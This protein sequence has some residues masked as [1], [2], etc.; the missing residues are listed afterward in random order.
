MA[1]ATARQVAVKYRPYVTLLVAAALVLVV[2]PALNDADGGEAR[3]GAGAVA[4]GVAGA[5][6][7]AGSAADGAVGGGSTPA[8]A[9]VS[10]PGATG[11]VAGGGGQ[12]AAAGQ[13][14]AED[15]GAVPAA[16]TGAGVG[17]E[18]ALAAPDCDPGTGRIR[19]PFMIAPPCV[20][21]W[22]EGA[23]NGGA[24]AQGVT[25]TEIRV[26][27][28]IDS[29]AGDEEETMS[30]SRDMIQLFN[31]MYRFWGRELTIE[32]VRASGTDEAA[33]RAD[34][35]RIAELEPFAL[36]T[37]SGGGSI[38][39]AEVA[40]RGIL[41][42]P[43]A[44]TQLTVRDSLAQAPY[45]WA[46]FPSDLHTMSSVA[47][48]IGKGLG[49]EPARWAGDPLLQTQPR[50]YG[51]VY[52]SIYDANYFAE[53]LARYNLDVAV[54]LPYDYLG[55]LGDPA[56]SQ[57]QAP[58][59]IARL[60]SA[61]VTTVVA[62]ADVFMTQALTLQATTNQFSP[63]W[64]NTGFAAQDF[65]LL[66]RTYDQTQWSHAFGLTPLTQIVADSQPNAYRRFFRWYWGDQSD[67]WGGG[68]VFIGWLW[69]ATGV[70]MAGPNLTP[71]TFRDGL[72]AFPASGGASCDCRDTVQ[73]SWGRTAGFPY[74]DYVAWD[75]FQM[76]W[77]S[78]TDTGPGN[79]DNPAE[80]AGVDPNGPGN[81]WY[82][83]GSRHFA[84]GQ[85]PDGEPP[86]FSRDNAS[87]TQPPPHPNDSVP[88][89][90]CEGCPSSS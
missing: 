42:F 50:V 13:P 56:T 6:G 14:A 24:T 73:Y 19:V 71:L 58:T 4:G 81:W 21:P 38:T 31:A 43:T 8:E 72:F 70:H 77:W 12:P 33:Q 37:D 86:M 87:I 59:I 90:P 3:V 23:D 74:D 60:K 67:N 20:I 32:F 52:P 25:A 35:I 76:I 29:Q 16:P 64:I 47:E 40:R 63:E 7:G 18:A 62:F 68:R 1:N 88:D 41:T 54:A 34:A 66:A 69:L 85:I 36:I 80:A 75:D 83:H 26:A 2:L 9:V 11:G 10:D 5:G 89:Y 65:A 46:E 53:E 30:N 27:V 44:G 39:E 15:G 51:V 55:S 22:P 78:A 28:L 57:Q 48:F 82:I 61:G 49:T 17:S 45:R 79:A 84:P